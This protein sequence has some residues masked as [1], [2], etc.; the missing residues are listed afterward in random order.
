MRNFTMMLLG[1]PQD[2]EII[3]S[4]HPTVETYMKDF[5]SPSQQ[6]K[7]TEESDVKEKDYQEQTLVIKDGKEQWIS[8]YEEDEKEEDIPE[9][10]KVERFIYR[11]LRFADQSGVYMFGIP[12]EIYGQHYNPSSIYQIIQD[13]ESD[14]SWNEILENAPYIE[15]EQY[16]QEGSFS[17]SIRTGRGIIDVISNNPLGNNDDNSNTG[18]D[19]NGETNQSFLDQLSAVN[20]EYNKEKFK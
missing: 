7:D 12:D 1:G 4:R 8:C 19:R 5:P 20:Y 13:C 18:D 15:R 3:T 6:W 17:Q 14:V 9:E 2:G 11:L 10:F 16:T